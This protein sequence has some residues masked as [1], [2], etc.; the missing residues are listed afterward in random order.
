MIEGINHITFSVR[1]LGRSLAFYTGVLGCSLRKRWVSGAY[2]EAGT[3]WV[4]LIVDEDT[5]KEPLPE[6]THTAFQ[7]SVAN[8]NALAL[9]IIQAGAIIWQENTSEGESLY[10]L[11]PDGHKLEIHTSN[12]AARLLAQ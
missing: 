6:Y 11:D 12:L 1:D 2:L 10:F 9:R 5:R 7:V 8:F 3:L 4:A